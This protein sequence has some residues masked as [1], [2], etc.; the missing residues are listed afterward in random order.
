MGFEVGDS[1]S[2]FV[3]ASP[4]TDSPDA[5]VL[6]K[7]LEEKGILVRYFTAPRIKHCL[8]LSIGTRE[9]NRQLLGALQGLVAA[10]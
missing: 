9:E 6:H 7:A 5:S 2:N 1:Q 3:L 10:K 8:R 4:P